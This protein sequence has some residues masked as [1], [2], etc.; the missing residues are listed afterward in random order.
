MT[1]PIIIDI[2]ASG[3]GAGSYPIEIGYILASG[4]T[5]CSLIKP[6]QDWLHWDTSAQQVHNI[7]REIL[8]EHG[9]NASL[10]AQQLND[11]LLNQTVYSD[12]WVH[13][14]IWMGRLFDAAETTPHFKFKDIRLILNSQQEAA[15]HTTKNQVVDEL[16]QQR[17]RA[18]I[19]A[20]VLQMTWLRTLELS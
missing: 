13:D 4:N 18:S 11:G 9:K 14:Y 1:P 17:H 20:K 19:D 12:S 6:E 15:W 16:G 2:E 5:W 7:S 3:F 10:I 8:L